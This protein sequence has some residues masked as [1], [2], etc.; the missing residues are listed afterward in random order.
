MPVASG[1]ANDEAGTWA[2]YAGVSGT[3]TVVGRVV[4]LACR[5]STSSPGSVVIDALPAIPVPS[6]TALEIDPRGLLLNP[7]VVFD[8]TTAYLVE[9]LR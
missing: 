3:V 2:Q 8:T 6:S 1:Q 5:T 9:V 4:G 7:V